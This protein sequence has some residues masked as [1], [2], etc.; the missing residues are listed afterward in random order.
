[1]GYKEFCCKSYGE[2]SERGPWDVELYQ[3]LKYNFS[4][5]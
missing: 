2:T 4:G 1:M 3:K 5:C